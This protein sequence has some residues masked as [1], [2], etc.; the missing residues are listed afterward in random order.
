MLA[1]NYIKYDRICGFGVIIHFLLQNDVG[2]IIIFETHN[3]YFNVPPPFLLIYQHWDDKSNQG[4]YHHSVIAFV[5]CIMNT[6][7][8]SSGYAENLC[9]VRTFYECN[10][11]NSKDFILLALAPVPNW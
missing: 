2:G 3:I 7:L 6:V 4:N 5:S 11:L 10:M 9:D 1:L 8:K